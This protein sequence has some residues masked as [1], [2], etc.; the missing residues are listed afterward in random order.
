M[1]DPTKQSL[2]FVL[3]DM[4]AFE[5]AQAFS[6]RILSQARVAST[7]V[8][9]GMTREGVFS[10]SHASQGSTLES[11]QD[12]RIP[13]MPIFLNVIDLA[14]SAIQGE[15]WAQVT[16]LVNGDPVYELCAGYLS[17]H[18]NLAWPPSNAIAQVP[19]RGLIRDFSGANPAAGAEVSD[20]VPDG[21]VWH[22]LAMSVTLVTS[23]TAA[24][25]RVHFQFF[26]PVS[27]GIETFPTIDQTASTTIKYN[28]AKY[29][30]ITDET[31]GTQILVP[32]PH[33]LYLPPG[34]TIATAT[35]NIQV[36]DNFGA[37]SY[38]IEQFFGGNP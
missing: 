32:L 6:L 23:A 13:D 8:V 20:V 4:L 16:L 38:L 5:H 15:I 31:D 29:G 30:A 21:Q 19:G 14:A 2:P 12:F 36:G 9:R 7:I 27:I 1:Q 34:G 35:V 18:K 17:N 28:V 26:G 33:D 3:R 37:P 10:F 22:V 24:N 11:Q 25:R